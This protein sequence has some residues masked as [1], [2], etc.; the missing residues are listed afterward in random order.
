MAGKAGYCHSDQAVAGQE[1][2]FCQE[3]HGVW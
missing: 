1:H 2:T 3:A